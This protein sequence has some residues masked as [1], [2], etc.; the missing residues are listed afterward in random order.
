V[1]QVLQVF[2]SPLKLEQGV[3]EA[4][5]EVSSEHERQPAE[6]TDT[7]D[8]E[9]SGDTHPQ[10]R[11]FV[12]NL[13]KVAKPQ[14]QPSEGIAPRTSPDPPGGYSARRTV[15]VAGCGRSRVVHASGS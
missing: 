13:K 11:E 8:R 9:E 6:P 4:W 1:F 12:R 15:Q 14:P 7:K 3:S 2:S 10:A 5:H